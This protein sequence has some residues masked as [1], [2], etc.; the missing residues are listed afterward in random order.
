MCVST[1]ALTLI[2]AGVSAYG[3]IQ[4]GKAQ[5]AQAEYQGAIARRQ[6]EIQNAQLEED[7][8]IAKIRAHDEEQ[9]RKD[10]MRESVASMRA[11]NKGRESGSFLAMVD[12]D[13][14]ALRFDIGNIRL[15]LAVTGSR[16]SS[17]IAI[18][19]IGAAGVGADAKLYEQA[20]YID[21]GSTLLRGGGEYMSSKTPPK[22]T[23]STT[24]GQS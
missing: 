4:M 11:L 14:E 22:K 2:S 19:T 10:K 18:N 7:L 9:I 6:A 21:A 16:I 20:G 23:R 15:G 3:S 5:R 8:K 13:E 12:A 1:A 17:Q 24:Y